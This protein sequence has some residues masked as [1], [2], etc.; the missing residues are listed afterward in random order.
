MLLFRTVLTLCRACN[1]CEV[2]RHYHDTN[3]AFPTFELRGPTNADLVLLLDGTGTGLLR[4]DQATG[5]RR[6]AQAVPQSSPPTD[7][8]LRYY[9]PYDL[10]FVIDHSCRS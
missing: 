9:Q 5:T 7:I 2:G 8:S 6:R 4:H 3:L 10:T 1:I